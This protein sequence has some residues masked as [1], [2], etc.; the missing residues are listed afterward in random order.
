MRTIIFLIVV[1]IPLKLTAQV[2]YTHQVDSDL[3]SEWEATGFNNGRVMVRDADGYFNLVFH[4]Q[5]NPDSAPGGACDI[6]YSHTL[7]PAPPTS[8]FDW[9]PA[10]KIV[11]LPGD[12]RYPSIAIEH[13][14]AGVSN[15]NDMLHVVLQHC[16]PGGV[17]DIFCCS[18]PN[19]LVPPP[20]V[21]GSPIP[22]YISLHNS[23][24]PDIDCSLGNILHVVWQEEDLDPFSE[25][26][27][28]QSPDHGVTW[29]PFANVSNTPMV[30][31]Q[32]PDVATIIDYPEL[33]S[34]YT[35]CSEM[36]HVA[37]NDEI[38]S[39]SPPHI[40]YTFSP[41]A[42]MSWLPFED[43]TFLSGAAG[44]AGYPSLTVDRNDIPHLA[45]TTK[46]WVHD[47]D[48]PGPYSPGFFPLQQNSFPG[49]DVGMYG[50]GIYTKV[51]YSWRP[52][53]IWNP[54]ETVTT[55][56][57]AEFPS[58][59]VDP[60]NN[61]WIGYQMYN[62]TDYEIGGATKLIGTPVWLLGN[63][64]NDIDHDDLFPSTATKKAGTSS[65]GYDLVWTK[66][67]SDLSAGGHGPA[68]TVSPAHE[69]WFTGNTTYS[70][71]TGIEKSP[72]GALVQNMFVYPNP[73][74]AGTFLL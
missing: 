33:P 54:V 18:N 57:D 25:I 15:D 67:D 38:D 34:Q 60:Y 41:D 48:T 26:L 46:N 59:A 58:I 32:M 65:T 7:I 14:S 66:I 50:T 62:G 17:Y 28:S 36:L 44:Q 6:W 64:S 21:W 29:S 35:Y 23:L 55:G 47:P 5:D 31:S 13:G 68:A 4:S 16:D 22:V 3:S 12:D 37:W 52:G 69:I 10:F 30:N 56:S 72:G 8:S 43:V 11:S 61:L 51:F 24:V 73:V 1:S 20:D 70:P 49:P 74:L 40:L 71:P 45:W 63:L 9:A 53:G 27:Y 39:A 19:S 42:G 2:T